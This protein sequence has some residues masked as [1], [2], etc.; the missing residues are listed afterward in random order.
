MKF[1]RFEVVSSTDNTITTKVFS[2]E[3]VKAKKVF[4]T[5]DKLNQEKKIGIIDDYDYQEIC[6]FANSM[7]TIIE[8]MSFDDFKKMILLIQKEEKEQEIRDKKEYSPW[9]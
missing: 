6:P 4:D 5:I 7:K 9:C 8:N 1:Y 3:E 2:N